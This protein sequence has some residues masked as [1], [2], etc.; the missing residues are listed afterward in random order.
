MRRDSGTLRITRSARR[1]VVA[2]GLL[3]LVAGAGCGQRTS[4]RS[5][6]NGGPLPDAGVAAPDA[7]DAPVLADGLPS[8][9][10]AAGDRPCV[11]TPIPDGTFEAVSSGD[12]NSCGLRPDGTV[13]C[14]GETVYP[15][16]AV[17]TNVFLHVSTYVCACG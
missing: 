7:R 6:V 15:Q 9:V 1:L 17:P 2:C 8:V 16:S 14:W 4:L 12:G 3:G 11:S 10:D 13:A 5:V